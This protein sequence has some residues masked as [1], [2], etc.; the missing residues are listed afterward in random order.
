VLDTGTDPY[1][2]FIF[3]MRSPKTREKCVGRLAAFFD[4]V[5]VPEGIIA[6]RCKVFCEKGKNDKHGNWVFAKILRFL[7]FQKEKR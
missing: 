5:E 3:A 2:V 4:F 1:S 6:E 7:Q